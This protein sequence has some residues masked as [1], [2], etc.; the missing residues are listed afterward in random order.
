M[1]VTEAA[2]GLFDSSMLALL[3]DGAVLVNVS[4]G[5]LVNAAALIEE[6]LS[7]RLPAALNVADP[8]PLPATH[9][10]WNN[11]NVVITPHVGA[12]TD[13]FGEDSAAFLVQQLKHC[14]SDEGLANV[15]RV[16]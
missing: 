15:V 1:P 11:P 13:V 4:R 2:R 12:F 3:K 16:I 7:G 8:E 14:A 5:E 9:P 10:Q 6:V